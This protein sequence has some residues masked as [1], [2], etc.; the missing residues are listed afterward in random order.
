MTLDC[1]LPVALSED[2]IDQMVRDAEAHSEEDAKFEEMVNLRNQADALVH[3][4]RKTVAEAGDKVDDAEKQKIEEAAGALEEAIKGGD[5]ADIE[6]RMQAL[7]EASAGLAQKMYADEAAAG[8]QAGD[9]AS[10]ETGSDG[11]TVDAEFEEV[12]DDKKDK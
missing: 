1:S 11:D 8:A 3:A 12:D 5:K 7:S 10:G 9:G 6:A 2:E 4:T